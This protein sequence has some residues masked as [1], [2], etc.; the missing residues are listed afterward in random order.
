MTMS[1]TSWLQHLTTAGAHRD[2]H[3][4][5][6]RSPYRGP[7]RRLKLEPL[8]DR[9]LLA[10]S[11][12][13]DYYTVGVAPRDVEV[14]DFNGDAIQDL[15]VASYGSP[16]VSVLLGY[17]DGTFQPARGAPAANPF[18][19]VVGDFNQDGKLDLATLTGDYSPGVRGIVS[20][21]LGQGDGTFA[22]APS[23]DSSSEWATAF[24]TG[25]LDN[26]GKLDLVL[27]AVYGYYYGY[28]SYVEVMLGHGDGTFGSNGGASYPGY[29]SS[30]RLADVNGDGNLDV[31]AAPG[32]VL[33]G[34]GDGT[35]QDP[36]PWPA[37]I[38]GQEQPTSTPTA[39]WTS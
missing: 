20:V 27:T 3:D 4:L 9:R 34:N 13:V 39:T 11:A 29:L 10:F 7:I 30:P 14:G 21:L 35:L 38:S 26:D 5:S 25:D 18:S 8:E 24:A 15:A 17:V 37:S 1:F 6:R 19:M 23:S 12:P 22:Q 31:A 16:G 33:L 32:T 28:Q 2:E 36:T